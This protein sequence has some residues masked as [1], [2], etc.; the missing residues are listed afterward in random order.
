MMRATVTPVAKVRQAV[1]MTVSPSRWQAQP[2]AKG[3]LVVS[4]KEALSLPARSEA[5]DGRRCRRADFRNRSGSR[6]RKL[7]SNRGFVLFRSIFSCKFA[8]NS[9]GNDAATT[10]NNLLITHYNMLKWCHT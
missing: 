4:C 8:E 7:N 10:S 5:E 3:S 9:T 1:M 6:P 2:S